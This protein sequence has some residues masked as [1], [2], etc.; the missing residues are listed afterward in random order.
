LAV[1]DVLIALDLL[2]RQPDSLLR[3]REEVHE[4]VLKRTPDKVELSDRTSVSVIPDAVCCLVFGE[5][6]VWVAFEIDRSTANQRVWREKVEA[7]IAWGEGPFSTR[8]G[9]NALTFAIVAT[10]GEDRAAELLKW[11]ERELEKLGRA[12]LAEFFFITGGSPLSLPP[13]EF[14]CG[15]HWRSP[16]AA[17]PLPLLE[18]GEIGL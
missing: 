3:I 15:E 17:R 7:L 1:N 4:Q 16:F 18:R 5:V 13:V 14:V 6:G 2:A 10:E 9:S 8:Y 11:T 12:D